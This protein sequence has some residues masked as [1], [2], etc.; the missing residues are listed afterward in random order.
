MEET[1]NIQSEENIEA[2]AAAVVEADA[3][4]SQ[5]GAEQITVLEGMQAVIYERTGTAH[6]A[7]TPLPFPRDQITLYGKTGSTNYALFAGFARP[8][9]NPNGPCLALAVLAESE[10]GGGTI[11]A[12]LARRIF[13]ACRQMGYL[14]GPP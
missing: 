2:T 9:D 3:E 11:A 12:P 5:Y 7:F 13:A 1:K 4:E 8:T 6:V 14:S 10:H